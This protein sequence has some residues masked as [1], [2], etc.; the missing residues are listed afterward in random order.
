M[1]WIILEMAEHIYLFLKD[2]LQENPLSFS[3]SKGQDKNKS[4]YNLIKVHFRHTMR[5]EITIN[6]WSS[7]QSTYY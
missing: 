3:L 4:T 2:I 7:N 1:V 6:Q 5:E